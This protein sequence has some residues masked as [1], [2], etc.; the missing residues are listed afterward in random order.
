MAID[1]NNI[2]QFYTGTAL[3]ED[4]ASHSNRVYFIKSGEVGYLYKGNVLIAQ[5]NNDETIKAIQTKI[6]ELDKELDDHVELYKTL[7]NTVTANG[8]AIT[9]N[10]NA[11]AGIKNGA[12]INDFAAVE[13][14]LNNYATKTEAKGYADAKD[15]AIKAAK[16]AADAAQADVDALE[17]KV[18]TVAEGKTVVGL[19]GEAKSAADAAQSDVDAL[20][21][22][23]GTIPE[24][25]NVDSVIAY[26]DK[27][28]TG[29]ASDSAL[30]ALDQR[31]TQ[32]ETDINAVEGKLAGIDSTVVDKINTAV[33]VEKNRAELVE[34]G[35]R[36]DVDSKAAQTALTAEVHRATAAEEALD[37][38]LDQVE[39]FFQTAEGEKLDIALDTLVEIQTY[40]KAEG[41][42]ADE[43]VKN[44]AANA[45]AIEDMDK[46]YKA[47]DTTLQNTINGVANRMTTAEGKIDALQTKVNGDG[48]GSISK[49][50]ESAVAAEAQ[51]RVTGVNEAKS[52]AA[53]A[54]TKAQNAQDEVDAL[55]IVVAGKAAQTDLTALQSRVKTVE[56]DLNTATTGIKDKLT[57]VVEKANTNATNISAN[58]SDIAALVAALEWK[59]A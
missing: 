9:K 52:A 23:V 57:A 43:M 12:T 45:K 15:A 59:T 21:T 2:V 53:A 55:E 17:A 51:A 11:I 49:M 24:G 54:D 42:A 40:I 35:L 5:T 31:V 36:T 14:T 37:G 58:A 20:K 6:N 25:A 38:R 16:D 8:T 3:P 48:E 19:I 41:A 44:I 10:A 50:I 34:K 30:Q 27:K 56:D 4:A 39:T 28:T 29:I 18:G 32:A 47:A 46:A 13:A 7:V 22:Y 1:V 33:E 26:V